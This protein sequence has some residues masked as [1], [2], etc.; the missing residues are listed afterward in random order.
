MDSIILAFKDGGFMMYIILLAGVAALA[1]TVERAILLWGSFPGSI[2]NFV[3]KILSEVDNGRI[4]AALALCEKR[5]N[6]VTRILKA[7]L[8]YEGE[9]DRGMQNAVDEVAL[10]EIPKLQ[11]RTSYLAVIAQISTLLGLLGTI[12]GLMQSFQA[13]GAADASQK[14]AL[15]ASGISKALNTTA[16]GLFVA[17]P[18]MLLYTIIQRRT[19]RLIDMLDEYSVTLMNRLAKSRRKSPTVTNRMDEPAEKVGV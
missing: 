15:L 13:V 14:A 17:V 12:I 6:A 16:F 2:R 18:A 8:S 5:N 10:V 19:E 11:D 1:I 4:D 9:D 3:Q 7:V